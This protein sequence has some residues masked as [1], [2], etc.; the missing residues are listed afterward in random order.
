MGQTLHLKTQ[1]IFILQ[2]KYWQCDGALLRCLSISVFVS[3]QFSVTRLGRWID[4]ENDYKT[5]Y[6]EFMESVW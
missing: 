5:L 2:N 4:F 3:Y 1:L 6:P